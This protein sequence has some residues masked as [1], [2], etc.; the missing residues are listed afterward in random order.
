VA[1]TTAAL[2]STAAGCGT[3]AHTAV[4]PASGVATPPKGSFAARCRDDPATDKLP[5]PARP[6][7]PGTVT[8]LHLRSPDRSAGLRDVLVY[9]PAVADSARLPVLYLLHGLPGNPRQLLAQSGLVSAL[10]RRFS[11]RGEPF[12]VAVPDGNGVH[13]SDTEWADSVDGYDR[14][15][16]FV[17][18][19]VIPA[20]EGQH[21]RDV[22][23]RAIGGFSMGG[24]GA[25]NLA[26][27]HPDLFG[28]VVSIAGYFRIDDPSGVFG[29]NAGVERANSPDQNVARGRGLRIYLL[30]AEQE[31]LGLVKGEALRF[32]R[33]LIAASVPVELRFAPGTHVPSYAAT[34]R[35]E[36]LDFLEGGWRADR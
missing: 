4:P 21:P 7:R 6:T 29:G 3:A 13:H 34:Q 20:V 17:T 18:K 12:V 30:D 36:V 33:L 9:R 25:M 16:T 32:A 24:Y 27:R 11:R 10:D 8:V 2:A 23:H 5:E 1:L 28:Q 22:C 35:P 14:V 19:V 31:N 15:E 26:L